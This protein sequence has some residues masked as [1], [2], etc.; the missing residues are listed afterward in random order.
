[1]SLG[2]TVDWKVG[3]EH[4]RAF[5]TSCHY[6]TVHHSP[7]IEGNLLFVS[8]NYFAFPPASHYSLRMFFYGVLSG[9]NLLGVSMVSLV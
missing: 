9:E 8:K 3:W 2:R 5:T 6:V 7:A 1:V 4:N